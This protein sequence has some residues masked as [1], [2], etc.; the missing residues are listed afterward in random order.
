MDPCKGV[1][2]KRGHSRKP[3]SSGAVLLFWTILFALS[4]FLWYLTGNDEVQLPDVKSR[5]CQINQKPDFE[6][7]RS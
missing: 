5:K 1:Y 2:Q 7:L 4:H 3:N 6:Q